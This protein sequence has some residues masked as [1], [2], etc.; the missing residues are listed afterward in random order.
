MARSYK[1]LRAPVSPLLRR[2]CS[3]GTIALALLPFGGIL[4]VLRRPA[5]RGLLAGQRRA[6]SVP[7]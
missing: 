6:H 7:V 3:E 2:L 5:T 1:V 4:V